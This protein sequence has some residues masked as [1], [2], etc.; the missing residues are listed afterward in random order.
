[1]DNNFDCNGFDSNVFKSFAEWLNNLSPFEFTTLGTITG[2]LISSVLTVNE[3]NSIGNWFELVG[4]IILTFNAQGSNLQSS[5]NQDYSN[6]YNKIQSLENEINK[7]K[8]TSK[9]GI[10]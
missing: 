6:L 1:M 5:N 7:L 10:N 2:Y 9:R 4:Q 8:N 3:Q